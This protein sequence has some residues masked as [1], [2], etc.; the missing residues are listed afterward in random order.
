MAT[1]T[2]KLNLTSGDL[3]SNDVDITINNA[4]T[5]TH[6][7][8]QRKTIGATSAGGSA[9]NL[10]TADDYAA[11]AYIYIK[12]TD[13]VETNYIYVYNDTTSG[14][15]VWL[16]IPGGEFAWL[17]TI[18]DKTLS[19]YATTAGTIVEVGVFGLDQ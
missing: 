16:K 6:G 2:A 8:I 13:S 14:D 12:N 15:P 7:G 11:V 18:A 17:P 4:L 1:I 19:A 10:Y 9:T 3:L 5:I